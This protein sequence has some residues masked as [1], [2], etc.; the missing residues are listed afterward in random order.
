VISVRRWSTEMVL[1]IGSISDH[2][3]PIQI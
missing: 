2:E 3:V 1:G